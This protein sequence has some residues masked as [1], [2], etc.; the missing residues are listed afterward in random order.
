MNAFAGSTM[1]LDR[2]EV[3]P[4]MRVLDAG[5]GPGRLTIPAA[6]RVGPSG[7][8]VALDVQDGMLA[9]VRRR[10]ADRGLANVRAVLGDIESSV[11]RT[12]I[13]GGRFDR[14]LLVAVL[15]EIPD[16]EG[17]MRA[18]EAALSLG[19]LLS[20]TEVIP[21]PH[22][23]TRDTVRRLAEGAGLR[24]DGTHATPLAFTMNFRKPA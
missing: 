23:E 21:D 13:G 12:D 5:S 11:G 3:G 4:G 9:R 17:A 10:A 18:L 24:F 16:Q 20:V 1:L 2:A 22:F 8:V 7:E 6:E 15:G 19:G 14:A